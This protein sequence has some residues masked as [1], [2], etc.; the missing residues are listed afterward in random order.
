MNTQ[1]VE[2]ARHFSSDRR[3]VTFKRAI[4]VDGRPPIHPTTALARRRSGRAADN[5]AQLAYSEWL[6]AKLTA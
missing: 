1:P 2:E 6:L 5:A 4:L 3:P